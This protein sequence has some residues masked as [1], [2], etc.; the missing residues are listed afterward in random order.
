MAIAELGPLLLYALG[1]APAPSASAGAG[2]AGLPVIWI[3]CGRH[4][5]WASVLSASAAPAGRLRAGRADLLRFHQVVEAIDAMQACLPVRFGTIVASVEELQA[6]LAAH[7]PAMARALDRV[8]GRCEV[9]ITALWQEGEPAGN[10]GSDSE[11]ALL[12]RRPPPAGA[13]RARRAMR[14]EAADDV[15]RSSFVA[16]RD[17][18]ER[19][20]ARA[21]AA[22]AAG[23][24]FPTAAAAAGAA[25]PTSPASEGPGAGRRYLEARRAAWVAREQRRAHATRLA[26]QLAR[27]LG[28]DRSSVRHA[29]C[30]SPRVAFSSAYLVPRASA[31]ELLGRA[32]ALRVSEVSL[33][34]HG[35][36]PPYSFATLDPEPAGSELCRP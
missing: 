4:G 16:R 21:T 22:P 13:G 11:R 35:P 31:G 2:V 24:A 28:V 10:D 29:I 19:T 6:A 36:W 32:R 8:R 1:E 26:E 7:G 25:L 15:R 17:A 18:P 20:D 9:A 12:V 5:A 30:P 14:D 23:A 3:E 33:H 34:L 27:A